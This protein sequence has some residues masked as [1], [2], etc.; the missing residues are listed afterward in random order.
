MAAF[1]LI[2]CSSREDWLRSRTNGIGGSDA[3]AVVGRNPYKTNI[4]LFEEKTGRRRAEDISGKPYVIYGHK[5]EPLI[6]QLF[7][8]DYPEYSVGYSEF[9]I[10]RSKKYPFMQATLD[11]MLVE[12]ET[13]RRGILEIK[14]TN[15]LASQQREK[16]KDRVP[17][18]YYL[19][20]LHY[21]IVTGW[22]FAILRA[23]LRSDWNDGMDRRG[24]IRNYYIDRS[25][26]QVKADIDY[27]INEEI[28]FWEY[29][30]AGRRPPLVLPEI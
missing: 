9:S 27:L 12:K 24:A 15:I 4:D 29:V 16:W 3:S 17:D 8:L 7:E 20:V 11:G 2:N 10:F 18:N 6:R 19:Q 28:K 13:G 1:T 21:L 26:P 14:T 23:L 22:D 5:A 30:E 25:D